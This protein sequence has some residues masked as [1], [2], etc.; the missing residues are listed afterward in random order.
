MDQEFWLPS[1]SMSVLASSLGRIKNPATG[2]IYKTCDN[3][4]GYGYQR[5]SMPGT[6]AK[7]STALALT[8]LRPTI[9][10]VIHP[11][12]DPKTYGG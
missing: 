6:W 11:T 12:I 2:T 3:G 9:S 7:H 4:T 8:A 5:F 10:T 1:D